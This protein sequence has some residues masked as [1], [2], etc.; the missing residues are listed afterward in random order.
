[1]PK[2]KQR[3]HGAITRSDVAKL[4]GV[5]TAVVSY[6]IN[7]GPRPVAE[8]TRAKV[9]DAIDRL[10]YIPNTAARSLTTG[11]ASLIALVVPDLANPYF[12]SLAKQVES[13]AR[14]AGYQLILVQSSAEGFGEVAESLSGQLVAGIITAAAPI[15]PWPL[16]RPALRVP[17]VKLGAPQQLDA[18]PSLWPDLYGGAVQ[19]TSHLIEVHG[20]TKVG[21]VAGPDPRDERERG[22]EDTLTAAG[23]SAHRIVRTPWSSE[24][25]RA[26]AH[27]LIAEHPDITA[28]FVASDQQAI[29]LLAGLYREGLRVPTDVAVASVDGSRDAAYTLPPLTTVD[30][31]IAAIAADGVAA[32]VHG[33]PA[34]SR[35]LYPTAL[36]VRQTCGCPEL[37]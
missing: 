25:G 19:A 32:I 6:V 8:A 14:D 27:E 7:N 2:A 4:A 33:I 35:P 5:S 21:M 37:D 23:L 1:M 18:V 31:P 15:D 30:V 20:H 10:G 34:G 17:I 11:R 28:V 16:D 22:W 29:G 12:S 36:H 9:Q 26:A 24:G 3:A 13:A